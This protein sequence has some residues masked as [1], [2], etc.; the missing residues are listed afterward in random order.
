MPSRK[1]GARKLPR[2]LVAQLRLAR[3]EQLQ[4]DIAYLQMELLKEWQSV[5]EEILGGA[6]IEKG[7]LRAWLRTTMRMVR[8]RTTRKNE[9]RV[10]RTLVVR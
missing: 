4:S 10:S 6:A 7:P 9:W 5:R 1:L 8:D 2:A 3:I